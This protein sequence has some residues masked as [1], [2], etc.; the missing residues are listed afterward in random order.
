MKKKP[1]LY[2]RLFLS[3][4]FLNIFYYLLFLYSKN[5][6]L[7]LYCISLGNLI[8]LISGI[9]FINK[10]LELESKKQWKKPSLKSRILWISGLMSLIIATFLS[11]NYFLFA[12]LFIIIGI[13]LLYYSKVFRYF[14]LKK[15]K[16]K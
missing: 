13:I 16:K 1:K 4:I 12:L 3:L 14:K 9:F 5:I 15:G 7:Y 10:R 8:G 2:L 11:L 6:S